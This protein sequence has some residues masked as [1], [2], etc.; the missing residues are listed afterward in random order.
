MAKPQSFDPVEV[1]RIKFDKV[2]ENLKFE[3][4]RII[5]NGPDM[6]EELEDEARVLGDIKIMFMLKNYINYIE[7]LQRVALSIQLTYEAYFKEYETAFEDVLQMELQSAKSP[8][9]EESDFERPTQFGK[10]TIATPDQREILD[11]ISQMPVSERSLSNLLEV[12]GAKEDRR[13]TGSRAMESKIRSE[14]DK[15]M[16]YGLISTYFKRKYTTK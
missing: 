11:I 7:S 2:I 14:V 1:I 4:A 13:K 6:K 15:M 8:I 3:Q 9:P 16:R 12:M 5:K 10:E